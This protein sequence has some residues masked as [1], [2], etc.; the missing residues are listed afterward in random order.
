MID[1]TLT[2]E[3]HI[4]MIIWKLS[5]VCFAVRA[6]TAFVWLD[7]LKMVYNFYFH[8]VINYGITLGEIPHI[9]IVFS[10]YK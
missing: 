10:I 7:T 8:V 6:I 5:V 2:W 9:V 3:S 4:E 1:N